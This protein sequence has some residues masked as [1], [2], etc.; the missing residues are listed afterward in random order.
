VAARLMTLRV[1]RLRI[2][3]P[4]ILWLGHTPSPARSVI[5]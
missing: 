4:L 2:R 5:S 1:D 3:P